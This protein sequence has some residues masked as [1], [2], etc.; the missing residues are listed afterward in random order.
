MPEGI[1]TLDTRKFKPHLYSEII[2]GPDGSKYAVSR[3][4]E[5]GTVT[6][7]YHTPDGQGDHDNAQFVT[8]PAALVR[9]IRAALG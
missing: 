4:L 6:L 2:D 9:Q 7:S 3:N 5:L 1:T 8:F